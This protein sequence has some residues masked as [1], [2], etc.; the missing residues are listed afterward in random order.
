MPLREVLSA[1]GEL[2]IV[3]ISQVA[4]ESVCVNSFGCLL[5]RFSG[6]A[7]VT[8][9][10]IFVDRTREYVEILQ[11]NADSTAKIVGVDLVEVNAIKENLPIVEIVEA[12]KQTD[13][14]AFA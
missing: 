7:G 3:A 13:Q 5:H 10:D 2:S 9:C 11:N 6:N 8:Q 12:S 1:L 4:D 14:C